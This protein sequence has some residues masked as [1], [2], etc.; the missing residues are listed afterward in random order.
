MAIF[1]LSILQIGILS[2]VKTDKPRNVSCVRAY[3]YGKKQQKEEIKHLQLKMENFI[4]NFKTTTRHLKKWQKTTSNS[5]MDWKTKIQ[6]IAQ[7]S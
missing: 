1:I 5:E 6:N 7:E 4:R 3:N 2:T